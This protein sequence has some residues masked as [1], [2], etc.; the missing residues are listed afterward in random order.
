MM[1]KD[2]N[3]LRV[4][5]GDV[6]NQINISPESILIAGNKVHIT[7]QTTIDSGV[8]TSAMIGSAAITTAKI[9]DAAITSARQTHEENNVLK[10]FR[11][12]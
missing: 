12:R 10:I 8:M 6:I 2:I 4:G 5:K 3:N 9:A 11:N 1:Q 7:G